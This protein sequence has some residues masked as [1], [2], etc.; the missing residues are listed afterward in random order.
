M[1][2]ALA[3]LANHFTHPAFTGTAS[4]AEVR[5]RAATIRTNNRKHGRISFSCPLP[6][7]RQGICF[8][9]APLRTILRA[10]A[11]HPTLDGL[12]RITAAGARSLQ[13]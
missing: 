4:N 11:V 5:F 13:A 8:C 7:R 3:E 1:T 10:L 9:C 6:F 12:R 2:R